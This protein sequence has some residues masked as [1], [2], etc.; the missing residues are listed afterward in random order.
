MGNLTDSQ[1]RSVIRLIA[2]KGKDQSN[3][4]GWRPITIL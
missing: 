2:K 3:I 1:K 4:K